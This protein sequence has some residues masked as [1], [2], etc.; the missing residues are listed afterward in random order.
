[1]TNVIVAERARARRENVIFSPSARVGI[2]MS[3]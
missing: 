2:P 1:M 3:V